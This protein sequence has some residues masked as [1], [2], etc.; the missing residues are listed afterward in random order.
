M[1]WLKIKM[2]LDS[3]NPLA[4]SILASCLDP[5]FRNLKFF[6]DTMKADVKE[7]LKARV[8][9]IQNDQDQAPPT[10]KTVLDKLLG[11]EEEELE[12]SMEVD[13]LSVRKANKS[14]QSKNPLDWWKENN[15]H[16][17]YLAQLAK[18]SLCIQATSTPS[19]RLFSKAGLT[20]SKQ[21]SNLKTDNVNSLLFLNQNSKVL[22]KLLHNS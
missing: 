13:I 20:I 19:E 10:K 18:T 12:S 7:E 15:I 9:Q 3:I 8:Q 14:T 11:P 22:F 16:F 17:P 4:L 5:R 1:N 2:V 21:R 6:H